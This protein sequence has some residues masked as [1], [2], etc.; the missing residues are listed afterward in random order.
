M[1]TFQ[2]PDF[3]AQLYTVCFRFQV[4]IQK[5]NSAQSLI[6]QKAVQK[7]GRPGGPA[8]DFDCP[9]AADYE[10]RNSLFHLFYPDRLVI[11]YVYLSHFCWFRPCG[12]SDICCVFC[13]ADAFWIS[14]V[15]QNMPFSYFVDRFAMGILSNSS[16]TAASPMPSC[17]SFVL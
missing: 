11:T 13:L 9:V 2:V 12:F 6:L 15:W 5:I 4:N 3:C 1:K 16:A 7:P 17:P 14:R 10:S 8:Q